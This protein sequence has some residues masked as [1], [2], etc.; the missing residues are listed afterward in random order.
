MALLT[1]DK[2]KCILC[3][4]CADVCPSRIISVT[5]NGPG[6]TG[7]R[8][9]IACGHCVAVCP[10]RALDNRRNRLENQ[11]ELTGFKLP[12]AQEMEKILRSRRSCRVYHDKAVPEELVRKLLDV[13]R[14]APTGGNTQGLSFLV[15]SGREK[16]DAFAEAIIC[17]MEDAIAKQSPQSGYFTG[18]VKNYRVDGLDSVLRGAQHLVVAVA[19]EAQQR[20]RE[21]CD[22]VW[23]YAELFAPS[24]GLGTCIAGFAQACAFSGWRQ[25]VELL[26]LPT[27]LQVG[28]MLMLGFPR[29]KYHR[30]AARQPLAVEFR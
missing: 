4:A 8:T 1:V 26:G 15:F 21:N 18:V 6:K 13:A 23:S 16:L 2:E 7:D 28:G 3:G 10:V 24:L 14:C 9:C 5:E 29:Y 20:A 22:F 27:G 11:V 25:L 30:L 12:A 17:W 19:P